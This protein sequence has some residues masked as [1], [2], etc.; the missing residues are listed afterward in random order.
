MKRR[1]TIVLALAGSVIAVVI[2]AYAAPA[3]AYDRPPIRLAGLYPDG[4]G[5]ST[6]KAEDELFDRYP[7]I[8]SGA[9]LPA[10]MVGYENRSSWVDGLTRFWD[11]LLCG[12]HTGRGHAFTL[13]YDAKG[14]HAWTVYR[15]RGVTVQALRYG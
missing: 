10:I 2:A 12:G 4:W 14:R 9:C 6:T 7:G 15:L 1:P 3:Q 13:V 5:Q 8:Q 11:K